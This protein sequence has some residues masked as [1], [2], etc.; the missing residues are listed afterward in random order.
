MKNNIDLKDL[1]ETPYHEVW[2]RKGVGHKA[3]SIRLEYSY[4]VTWKIIFNLRKSLGVKL[5]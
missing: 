2:K 5:E 3:I 4:S 1:L